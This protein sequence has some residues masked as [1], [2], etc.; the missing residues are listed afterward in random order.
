MKRLVWMA[1]WLAVLAS[2]ALAQQ[3]APATQNPAAEERDLLLGLDRAFN[4]ATA[5]KG[6]EGWVAY[7]APNGSMLGA[8]EPPVTG[9]EAIR[10]YMEAVFTEPESSLRWQPTRAEM[11]IPGVLGYTAGRFERRRKTPAGKHA[12]LR[13]SYVTV[14]RKQADGSWKIILDTG[15]PDGPL[16]VVE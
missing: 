15:H 7:F 9:P 11:L 13:G 10:K 2:V 8:T 4:T 6:I 16:T 1:F 12:L 5:E 14:W 3:P